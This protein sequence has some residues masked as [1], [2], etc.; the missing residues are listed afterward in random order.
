[1]LFLDVLGGD[2]AGS[3][4][5][6]GVVGLDDAVDVGGVGGGA[7][8]VAVA[9]ERDAGI[10]MA[11]MVASEAS[12][13]VGWISTA[14]TLA[15]IMFCATWFSAAGSLLDRPVVT[16]PPSALTASSRPV[17]MPWK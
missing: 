2:F 9:N 13:A 17:W 3:G 6:R 15:W 5:Q 8:A 1:M 14:S 11:F 10:L 4:A 12:S 7:H 16:V